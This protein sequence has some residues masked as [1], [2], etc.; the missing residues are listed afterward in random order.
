VGPETRTIVS[1]IKQHYTPEQ[2]IGKKVVIVANLRP[3]K[4]R[5]VESQGMILAAED[6]DGNLAVATLDRDMPD[7]AEVR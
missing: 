5:G 6:A 2:L 7:G 4:L 3:V 1:G